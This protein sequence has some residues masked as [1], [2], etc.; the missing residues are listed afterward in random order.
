MVV[1]STLQRRV[2]LSSRLFVADLGG[3]PRRRGRYLGALASPIHHGWRVLAVV[4]LGSFL[5]MMRVVGNGFD[6]VVE[7]CLNTSWR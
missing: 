2:T 4:A 6:V 1:S 3:R 5:N 7:L